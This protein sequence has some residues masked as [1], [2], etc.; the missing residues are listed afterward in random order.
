[1]RLRPQQLARY[2]LHLPSLIVLVF[3]RDSSTP[4]AK[5][6]LG[7]LSDSLDRYARLAP[8]GAVVTV[9]EFEMRRLTELLRAVGAAS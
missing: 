2:G 7:A 9:T 3:S 5:L 6:E 4:L 8:D 1:M